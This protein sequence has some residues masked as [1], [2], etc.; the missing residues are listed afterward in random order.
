M[1]LSYLTDAE[2]RELLRH[3]DHAAGGDQWSRIDAAKLRNLA[4]EVQRLREQQATSM[5]MH[6]LEGVY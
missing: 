2:I 4:G 3:S 5:H 6:G 1:T